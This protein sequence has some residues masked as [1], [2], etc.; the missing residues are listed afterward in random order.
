MGTR[1]WSLGFTALGVG[2][3]VWSLGSLG[4]LGFRA[5][6]LDVFF[7]CVTCRL[8]VEGAL[9]LETNQHEPEF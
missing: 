7:P 2:V 9:R 4:S 5:Q 3:Q 1:I 8:Q 6:G